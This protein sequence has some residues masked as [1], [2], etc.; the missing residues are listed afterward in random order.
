[1]KIST[2]ILAAGK[3]TRMKSKLLKVLHPLAGKPMLWHPID[4]ITQLSDQKPVVVVGY[5]AD[6]VKQT[7][8]DLAEYVVQE[9]QL[10][11]GHAVMQAEPLLAGKSD[12][13][14]I[15]FGDMPLVTTKTLSA[16][17]DKQK[18]NP[19][20][21]SM[22]TVI[23]DD[24]R[25]FGRIVRNDRGEVEAI[26]EEVDCTPEQRAITELNISMYCFQA[27]WLWKH[28][29]KIPISAK[30]EYYLT[31][32]VS[33]AVAEGFSVNSLILE[34]PDEAVGI[35]NRVHLAYAQKVMQRRINEKWMLAGVTITNP[36]VT[37]IEPEVTISIA[38]K[39]EAEDI[40]LAELTRALDALPAGKRVMLKLTLPEKPNLYKSL[41][42]HDRVMRVVAL[43][44]GYSREEANSRLSQN[45][46]VIAS[47]SRALSEGLSADQSDEAF[48]ARLAAYIGYFMGIT[49]NCCGAMGYNCSSKL[50]RS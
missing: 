30:G 47:F 35:N 23:A 5:Q 19:G 41:A 7:L 39:A 1:M 27:E 20:P 15:L 46:D 10:G 3:G 18:N 6:A 9:E 13:V 33:L 2:L 24:P 48:D 32:A 45:S 11:T 4:Q 28:L 50:G 26:V 16:L 43:S 44:G 22:L 17:I 14:L 12:L 34:D 21:V 42:D 36:D 25:G 49:D 38:D 37:Y 8:G 29:P 40:L 31:D